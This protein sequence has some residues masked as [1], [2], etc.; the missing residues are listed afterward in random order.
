MYNKVSLRTTSLLTVLVATFF[1][2]SCGLFN[3]KGS[4]SEKLNRRGEVTGVPKRADWQQ[5]LPYDMVP[6]KSGT[7]WMGQSDEDIA[8]SQSSMNKQIT[9]SEFF[10]DKY[11]VSNNKYRQFLESV[12]DGELTLGTP[13]TLKE[14]PQFNYEELKPDTTV[15][16]SSFTFHYGDPLMEFYF[17]HPAFDN[18][19]VVGI[20]WDQAKKYCEWRTYYLNANDELQFDLPSFRLP[21][22]AEWEYAAKG[23]KDVAKY[24][25]GGPYLKNKRGCLMANFKPGRGNYIDDGFAYTAPVDVFAP[26][27]FGLY[28]MSG[29]VAEWVMDAYSPT[30]RTIT[31][32]LDPVYDVETEPRKITRGGSWKDINY[33]LETSTRTYEYQD[34]AQAHIGFRTVMTFIGRSGSMDVNSSRRRRL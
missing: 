16:S 18:Y 17:D 26:N 6:I 2:T 1:I 32:D 22:E 33:Y 34:V 10:M 7:F 11:E 24:P 20:T 14:E 5:N 3:K 25:W 9:I 12:R 15:W 23:G 13:T 29:N 4:A 19:P 27:G 28:N 8:Y 21:T 30:S 31:W